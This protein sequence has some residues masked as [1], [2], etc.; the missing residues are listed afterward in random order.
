VILAT[1]LKAEGA[2]ERVYSPVTLALSMLFVN[3]AVVMGLPNLSRRKFLLQ[4]MGLNAID[5]QHA[6]TVA[7]M[8]GPLVLSAITD[9]APKV[10][11][12][13][14]AGSQTP[15]NTTLGSDDGQW[16]D[17]HDAVHRNWWRGL[18]HLSSGELNARQRPRFGGDKQSQRLRSNRPNSLMSGQVRGD[19]S[20][21][22]D[23]ETLALISLDHAHDP[24][25]K[26]QEA[27]QTKQ[28]QTESKASEMTRAVASE[29]TERPAHTKYHA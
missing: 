18:L 13:Q 2:V 20:G 8:N 15:W 7:L 5:P 28:H 27:D 10:T 1:I 26:R 4:A 24:K 6:E 22:G 12:K 21:D 23:H 29:R 14:V 17:Y 19:V 25:D 11:R 9:K 16:S 3:N